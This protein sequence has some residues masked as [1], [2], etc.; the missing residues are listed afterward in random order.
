MSASLAL[1]DSR[2]TWLA[3]LDPALALLP[4][5]LPPASRAASWRLHDVR[6]EPGRGCRLAYRVGAADAAP[7]FVAVDV[8][9]TGWH[10]QDYRRDA[11][12]P[13][14]GTATDPAWV[15]ARLAPLFAEPI[16]GCEVE[17]VRYRPG[18]RCV[19]RYVVRTASG[20]STLY[21]KV[22]A[23]QRFTDVV[24]R[25]SALT[26]T[27]DGALLV[28][29][30]T[31]AWPDVQ[32]TVGAGVSGRT[33]SAILGDAGVPADERARLAHRLGDRLATFHGVR[34]VDAPTWFL[35]DQLMSLSRSV[36]A[37]RSADAAL[38][39]RLCTILDMLADELPVPAAPVLGHGGFRAG[40]VIVSQGGLVVLDTDGLRRCDPG[41]DLG[42]VLAHLRWQAIRRPDQHDVML[43]AERALLSG[44]EDRAGEVDPDSLSW[45]RAA[46]LLQVAV[47]RY[48]RLEIADWPSV[49]ALVDA[50]A[51]LVAARKARAARGAGANLLD[52]PQMTAL[53]R[54]GLRTASSPRTLEVDSAEPVASASGRRAV[55]RYRVRGLD[56]EEPVTVV[57]KTF[58]AARRAQLLHHHLRLLHD[59]PFGS[60][61]LRVPEPLGWLPGQ[62]LVLYRHSSGTQLDRITDRF[63]AE[64]GVRRAAVW[65]ARLHASRLSL[66]R[67]FS[68]DAEEE[69][70]RQWAAQ[71]GREQPPLTAAAHGL[72]VD[73]AVAAGS[74][75]VVE[76]VPIH[77]DFHAG[78]VLIGENTCVIDLD[79]ARQ[80]DPAFDVAHFCAYLGLEAEQRHG[81]D[82]ASLF[83]EEYS[84]ASG[85]RDHGS[86][87]PFLAYTWL[88]IAKQ[89]AVGSGPGRGASPARRAAGAE[90]ALRKG[91]ACLTG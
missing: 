81:D 47:R 87:G 90:Q 70:T 67:E 17:P 69:S 29:A 91:R 74:A 36:D 6:W 7:T 59:G 73:W 82:L 5:A 9:S 8:S 46:G 21:G 32:A 15:A 88:K 48:R 12:L 31:A 84:A 22:F 18:S 63:G 57:G 58:T 60:G 53:L 24:L 4:Q 50:A 52:R 39:D 77:K 42:N 66:P 33:A 54:L 30:M 43:R 85:W 44:Y 1:D 23:E 89:W 72:A 76:N 19:V 56:G 26:E 83:V 55:V 37:V 28:P 86:F 40:Q 78:H 71:V 61:D 25:M 64:D 38:G 16:E 2:A 62:R 13:G 35:D 10:R 34:A 49:P 79:E 65:L 14:L 41:C 20:T 51:D 11:G 68:Q 27:P 45:W 80:G 75:R 3:G